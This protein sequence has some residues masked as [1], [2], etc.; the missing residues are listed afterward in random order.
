[1][2]FETWALAEQARVAL[3]APFSLAIVDAVGLST[4]KIDHLQ[5]LILDL[6][7]HDMVTLC[8][9]AAELVI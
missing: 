9:R 3:L 2:S 1:M 4:A 8:S 5:R 7:A 6:I